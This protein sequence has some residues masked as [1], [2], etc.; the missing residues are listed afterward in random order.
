ME[1]EVKYATSFD[2]PLNWYTYAIDKVLSL[3]NMIKQDNDPKTT[4]D[5]VF[6]QIARCQ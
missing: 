2:N 1:Q 5:V 4:I 6:M 3:K